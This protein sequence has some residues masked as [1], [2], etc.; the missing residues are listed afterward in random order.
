MN[1]AERRRAAV[2]KGQST[3]EMIFNILQTEPSPRDAA[4]VL[5]AVHASLIW[6]QTQDDEELARKMMTEMVEGVIELW[7]ANR[8][9]YEDQ[10]AR[11]AAEPGETLQ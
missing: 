6:T 7:K 9:F 5:A 2:A 10:K 8:K 1:R 11:A 3:A 4:A